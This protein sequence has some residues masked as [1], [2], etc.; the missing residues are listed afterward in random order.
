MYKKIII[1]SLIVLLWFLAAVFFPF[2]N[3]YFLSLN[4]PNIIP[5][6]IVFEI[7]WPI[8]FIFNSLSIYI[9][10][11][12]NDFN[13]DYYFI[14]IINY[15]FCQTFPLFFS[16]FNSLI[17]SLISSIGT[18][19]TSYFLYLESK[20]NNYKSS[21]FLIPYLFMGAISTFWMI[22]ILIMN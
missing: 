12:D 2:D 8:I 14:L 11:K 17:L 15:I 4:S 7:I 9:I 18:S 1:I 6:K 20:K 3:G 22:I 10:I 13:N 5:S 19:I 21:Y 16:Y